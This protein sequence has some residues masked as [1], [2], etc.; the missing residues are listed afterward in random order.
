MILIKPSYEILTPKDWIR[1]CATKHIEKIGRVCYKSEEKIADASD[2]TFVKGLINRGHTAMLEHFSISVKLTVDRGVSHEIVRHRIASFAQEST[3]YCN[4]G[5]QNHVTF[6]IPPWVNIAPGIYEDVEFA[7]HPTGKT[8]IR[9]LSTQNSLSPS[10]EGSETDPDLVWA[11]LLYGSERAYMALLDLGW[12][13]EQARSVLPNSL[14]TEITVTANLREWIHIF[15]L[16]VIGTTGK[17]H[18][19]MREIMSWVLREFATLCPV[20][21]SP[22]MEQYATKIREEQVK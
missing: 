5:K 17:P 18:P 20:V 7:K 10:Y 8:V 4:Y 12:K 22:L 21:Y 11:A 2:T 15:E 9:L 6:I 14:K 13:P 16:R 19:Q 3:R 1:D